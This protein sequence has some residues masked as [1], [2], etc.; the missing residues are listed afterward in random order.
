MRC[1]KPQQLQHVPAYI[2]RK[3]RTFMYANELV[4]RKKRMFF[5]PDSAVN[6]KKVHTFATGLRNR[7]GKSAGRCKGIR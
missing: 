2:E 6:I 5:Q 3:I 4:V 7:N 1:Q